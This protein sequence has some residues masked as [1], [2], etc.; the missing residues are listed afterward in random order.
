MKLKTRPLLRGEWIH[1]IDEVFYKGKWQPVILVL[2]WNRK[3]RHDDM[4]FRCA[5]GTK[6]KKSKFEKELD[7][8]R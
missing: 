6:E 5:I 4:K 3:V 1:Q 2:S 7:T 8:L